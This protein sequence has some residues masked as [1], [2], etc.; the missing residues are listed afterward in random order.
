MDK[1]FKITC[2][3]C[4][5]VLIVDRFNGEIIEVRKPII[6]KSS[7]DRFKDA[8]KKYTK[9]KKEV[10]GKFEEL[11]KDEKNK[12]KE[13]DAFFSKEVKEVKKSGKIEKPLRDIDLD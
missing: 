3:I 9:D 11:K 10:K 8:F 12:K 7:G 13:L 6:E 2:P 1:V 4:K 5:S